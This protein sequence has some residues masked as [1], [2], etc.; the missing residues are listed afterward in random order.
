[1]GLEGNDLGHGT[2]KRLPRLFSFPRIGRAKK[3]TDGDL[4]SKQE[5]KQRDLPL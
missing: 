3:P 1:M 5:E 2:Q 4:N